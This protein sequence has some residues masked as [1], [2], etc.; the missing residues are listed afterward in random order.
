[1]KKSIALLSALMAITVLLLSGCASNKL[2]DVF[3]EEEVIAKAESAVDVINTGDYEEVNKLL[4]EDLRTQLTATQIEEAFSPLLDDAG[5]FV[6]VTN[7]ATAG[8]TVQS[9]GEKLATVALVCK[10]ENASITYTMMMDENLN[11]VGLYIK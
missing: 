10:Y 6:E 7:T 2:P 3:S 8:Q 9:T 11:L 5:A 4:R 1:M